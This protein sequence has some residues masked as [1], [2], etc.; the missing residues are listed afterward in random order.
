M[1]QTLLSALLLIAVLANGSGSF[2]MIEIN[3]AQGT[4][5]FNWSD[6]SKHIYGA[7]EF[8]NMTVLNGKLYFYAQD[9]TGNE[10]LWM[11]DGTQQG[12]QIVK[13]LNP[14]GSS[15]MG[16]MMRLGDK[17]VFVASD[18]NNWD[19]D[20]FASDGT[21]NGTTKIADINQ[22]WNEVL[23]NQRAAVFG[24]TIL[25]CTN[26]DLMSTDGTLAGTQSLLT[27]TSYNPSQGYCELNGYAYFVLTNYQ[28][29]PQLWRTDGT[30]QGTAIALDIS[31]SPNNIISVEKLLAYNG[32]LYM[33]AA[34]NGEGNDLFVY[35]GQSSLSHIHLDT[36][37]NAYPFEVNVVDNRLVFVA[38]N[39]TGTGLYMMNTTDTIPQLVEATSQINITSGLSFAN[40]AVYFMGNN[41]HD[42]HWVDMATG[43]HHMLSLPHHTIPYYF[44]ANQN[45]MLTGGDG[46]I[47]FAANDSATGHQVFMESNG[48]TEGTFV[49]MPAGAN[50]SHP[51]NAIV[52]C[53]SID[54]FDWM[55]WGNKVVIPANFTNAGRELWIYE[56]TQ[57]P[58]AVQPVAE[59]PEVRLFPNP[60]A[61]RLFFHIPGY[62][63]KSTRMYITDMSGATVQTEI[64]NGDYC[65]IDISGLPPGNYCASLVLTTTR[66]TNTQKF[67]VVK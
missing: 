39:T 52:S 19:F 67:V 2:S 44:W 16:N 62:T 61:H 36:V 42:I 66:A 64:L 7:G 51:F 41:Q 48:T 30:T 20:L 58:N 22:N 60:A 38:Y 45:K 1:K 33:V 53:G 3:P 46:K 23:A 10:E 8:S 35:D 27:L 25:F 32:K 9:T 6:S 63:N 15:Q 55:M 14:S 65:N 29:K 34:A 50:T 18:N 31:A 24:N 4:E 26:T 17:L 47:Y 49:I 21:P 59:T 11:S 5:T 56:P 28:G 37:G 43:S 57:T 13:D 54:V 40:N 12:T